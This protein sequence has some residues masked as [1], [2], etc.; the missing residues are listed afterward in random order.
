MNF[1]LDSSSGTAIVP[2]V[3]LENIKK[4]C[5]AAPNHTPTLLLDMGLPGLAIARSLGCLGIPVFVLDTKTEHWSHATKY[6]TVLSGVFLSD[7]VKLLSVLKQLHHVIGDKFLLIPLHDGYVQF[8]SVYRDELDEL[9]LFPALPSQA[10]ETL[11]DKY[12]TYRMCLKH[13]I[14]APW[15]ISIN[16]HDDLKKTLDSIKY[17]CLI[18]PVESRNWQSPDAWKMLHGQKIVIVENQEELEHW[19]QKL[20][21]LDPRLIIQEHIPGPGNNL[22][23]AVTYVNQNGKNVGVFVG[24]KHRMFPLNGGRGCYVESIPN[25]SVKALTEKVIDMLDYKGNIGVEFKYDSRDDTYKLIEVNARF[26]I[27]DG[28]AANCGLDVIHAAY[29][30]LTGKEYKSGGDYALGKFWINPEQDIW[31][32]IQSIRLKKL[33]FLGWLKSWIKPHF[34][35]VGVADDRMPGFL[36]WKAMIIDLFRKTIRRLQT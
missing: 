35:A 16:D 20:I 36:F 21:R 2:G 19:H 18:K 31:A 25:G 11:V 24:R 17:P 32:G 14:P 30:D 9:A 13:K 5:D 8:T 34:S 27:W 7:H 12:G 15:T 28:F 10:V 6:A 26:G 1:Q 33:S 4:Q 23:Y 3:V 29:C 22:V